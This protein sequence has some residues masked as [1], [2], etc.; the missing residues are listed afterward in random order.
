MVKTAS[1]DEQKRARLMLDRILPVSPR[2]LGLLNDS[3]V[4]TS[5]PRYELELVKVPTLTISM[6]DDLFGTYDGAR[7]TAEHIP[8]ARFLGY[9]SGGHVWIGHHAEILSQIEDF[10]K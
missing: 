7:Y 1:A 4:T 9:E 8:G 5:L 3:A 6:K 2:R 10:L